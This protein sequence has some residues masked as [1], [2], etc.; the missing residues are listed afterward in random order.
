[1]CACPIERMRLA[2]WKDCPISSFAYRHKI[3]MTRL[4]K[5][6]VHIGPPKT[7]TTAL[8]YTL[9]SL[10]SSDFYYGGTAQPRQRDSLEFSN[11]LHEVCYSAEADASEL[12]AEVSRILRSGRDVVVSQERLL[13]DR[14]IV[15]QEKLG[16]LRR[17]LMGFDVT[18]VVCIRDPIAGLRSL[19]QEV[20]GRL[21]LAQKLSFRRFLDSNQA[22]VF[23][24]H[25]LDTSIRNAGFQSTRYI[26]FDGL[27]A[28]QLCLADL[29]GPDYPVDQQLRVEHVNAGNYSES[30]HRKLK[31]L[32]LH[33]ALGWRKLLPRVIINKIKASPTFYGA[34]QL[35][36]SAP[37]LPSSSRRLTVPAA[38]ADRLREAADRMRP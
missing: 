33:H 19:Y 24:Y 6:I 34:W 31:R 21:P 9:Q 38:R 5:I 22:E 10:G 36:G 8:Q 32:S 2:N 30:E 3:I 27:T 20:F 1:M 11:R 35:V 18:L 12:L 14:P 4:G 17:L 16:N 13:V 37:I 25:N 26:D 23:D 28:G 15:H 7:A 29:L